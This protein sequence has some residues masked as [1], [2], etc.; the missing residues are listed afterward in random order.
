M[1]TSEQAP[2]VFDYTVSFPSKKGQG[3]DLVW[4]YYYKALYILDHV[5]GKRF[6]INIA[7]YT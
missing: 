6:D 2:G 4:S 5:T 7:E 1:P 3:F